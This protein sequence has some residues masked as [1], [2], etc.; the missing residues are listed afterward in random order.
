[1]VN[2]EIEGDVLV[3]ANTRCG[4]GVRL[5]AGTIGRIIIGQRCNFK[6]GVVIA[7]YGGTVTIGNRV[8]IGE[9][10]VIYGHGGVTIGD[11][12]AIAPHCAISSQEHIVGS[13]IALRFSGERLA[14]TRIECGA[15]VSAHCVVTA[16]IRIGARTLV[17]AGSV[18]T[19]SLPAG[20]VAFG[21]PCK[22]RE[23]IRENPLYG[24]D[25]TCDIG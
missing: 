13:H 25:D 12:V 5:L 8:S 18:V 6:S 4:P 10:T 21:T 22:I 15:I 20:V 19:D 16:G 11:A 24:L 1:M 23:R 9:Y 14:E 17:G 2:P 3:G 7:C